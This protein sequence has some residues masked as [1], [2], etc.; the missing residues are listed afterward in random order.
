MRQGC[1]IDDISVRAEVDE[2]PRSVI[3][4]GAKVEPHG[5]SHVSDRL[6]TLREVDGFGSSRHG[7]DTPRRRVEVESCL[8]NLSLVP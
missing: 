4:A 3:V 1:E 5:R 8:Q 6:R 2:R 7:A